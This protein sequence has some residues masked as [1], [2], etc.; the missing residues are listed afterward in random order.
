MTNHRLL[1]HATM[2]FWVQVP[3]LSALQGLGTTDKEHEQSTRA[4]P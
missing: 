2:H 1:Q 4:G 3:S